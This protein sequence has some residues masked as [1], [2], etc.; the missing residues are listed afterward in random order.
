MY[1]C[2]W[3]VCLAFFCSLFP[4]VLSCRTNGTLSC[5]P[6]SPKMKHRYVLQKAPRPT[7][8]S[9]IIRDPQVSTASSVHHTHTHTCTLALLCTAIEALASN[10]CTCYCIEEDSVSNVCH[11]WLPNTVFVVG[12]NGSASH[13]IH[14]C[15]LDWLPGYL[16][17]VMSWWCNDHSSQKARV[18]SYCPEACVNKQLQ[19]VLCQVYLD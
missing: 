11:H 15:W 8:I 18:C 9:Q 13:L 6:L 5:A 16:S 14:F 10:S 1:W 7:G 2:C 19:C 4:V 17:M 3:V 12:F